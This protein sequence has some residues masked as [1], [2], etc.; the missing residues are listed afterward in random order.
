[1]HAGAFASGSEDVLAAG[2]D[3]A[4]AD[5]QT[6]GAK[7]RILHAVAVAADV[8]DASTGLVAALVTAQR[9]EERADPAVVEFVAAPLHPPL[10]GAVPGP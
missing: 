2:L 5:A 10:G 7:L 3:D 6:H 4:G 9:R 1:M 8:P